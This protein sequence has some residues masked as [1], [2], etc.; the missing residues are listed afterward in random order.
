VLDTKMAGSWN[1]H[2]LTRDLPLDFFVCFSSAA[3][4]LGSVAQASYAAGNA[5][6]DAVAHCRVRE[7]LKGLAVNW[8]TWAEVGMAA[9]LPEFRRK[10]LRDR[11]LGPIDPAQAVQ[12]LG[13][14]IA[15]GRAQVGVMPINWDKFFKEV[16]EGTAPPYLERLAPK[17]ERV[18]AGEEVKGILPKVRAAE[19]ANRQEVL[20]A[21]VRERVAKILGYSDPAQVDSE[22]TLLELGFDSLMAVQLRNQIR[23]NLEVDVPIGKLFDSTTVE[24]LTALLHQRLAAAAS[25]PAGREQVEVI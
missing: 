2:V 17:G 23:T 12:V 25:A 21:Y 9:T 11:G 22:L 3:S 4:L 10:A 19:A 24:A 13:D 18:V 5:F 16:A 14:L 1:L 15:E 6:K 20:S 8:G 7:G